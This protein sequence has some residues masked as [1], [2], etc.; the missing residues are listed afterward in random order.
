MQLIYNSE[1]FAVMQ[2]DA[3]PE[4]AVH[5]PPHATAQGPSPGRGGFEIVDKVSRREIY[6]EGHLAEAFKKGVEALNQGSPS[7]D[8]YDA[9]ME[10][11]AGLMQQ[12][13][14]VH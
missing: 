9:Y 3:P 6:L 2:F 10:G 13:V 5:T 8:D 11:F 4:A 12:P 7:M 1:A 14:V